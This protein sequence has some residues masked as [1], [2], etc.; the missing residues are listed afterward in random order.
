VAG[1]DLSTLSA[2][3]AAAATGI[4][5][6]FNPQTSYSL[7]I[8]DDSLSGLATL[9]WKVAP[10]ILLYGSYSRGS[11]S[12]GLNLTNIPT[13]A[14]GTVKPETVDNFELGFKSQWLDRRLTFNAAAFWTEVS[15][16]Q[17]AITQPNSLGQAIQYISNIPKVRSRGIEGDLAYAPSKWIS[18]TASGSYIEA[19]YRNYTNAP[20]A[21][22]NNAALAP[23][24]NLT[25]VQ[26]P[27]V[28][29]FTYT[30]GADVAQPLGGGVI[31]VYGHADYSHRS[32]FNTSSSNSH[33]AQVPGYGLLNARIGVRSENGRWD[34]SVW[35]RNLTDKNYFQALSAAATG[36]VTG[37]IGDPRTVGVTLKTKL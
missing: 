34:I 22:E 13:G 16:Y 7:V 6:Q 32:T 33:Y 14:I 19:S 29:K 10:A 25:G 1:T 35:A 27:G 28:P 5:N 8:R 30:L 23:T 3:D 2:A 17:T 18:M 36:L 26:L 9:G 37:T 24:Q 20:Q 4:R 21:P 11:K 31:E 12:G 15:D